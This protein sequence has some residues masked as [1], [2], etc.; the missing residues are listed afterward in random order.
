MSEDNPELVT[1]LSADAPEEDSAEKDTEEPGG[2]SAPAL[3]TS[4]AVSKEEDL[5]P[6]EGDAVS[7]DALTI[8]L[9]GINLAFSDDEIE[10]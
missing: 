10:W 6:P 7:K 4:V 8:R 5:D 9:D 3:E 1:D 2:K